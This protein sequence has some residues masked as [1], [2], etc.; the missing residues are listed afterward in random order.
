M[1][2]VSVV[3]SINTEASLCLGHGATKMSI[4]VMAF[5]SSL[6]LLH[7]LAALD[8][9]STYR[10]AFIFNS[11]NFA[12]KFVLGDISIERLLSLSKLFKAHLG[13]EFSFF[14]HWFFSYC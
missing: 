11:E 5:F 3:D 2:W 7:S 10:V 14:S 1:G 6:V 4:A 12:R 13:E 9:H 8:G